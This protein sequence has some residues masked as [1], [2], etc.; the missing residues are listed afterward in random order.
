MGEARRASSWCRPW[1]RSTTLEIP[2]PDRVAF[3]TQTTLSVDE[4]GEIIGAL[5]ASPGS[6][7][8]RTKT[9]VTRPNRQIAV[10]QL[11]QESTWCS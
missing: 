11:A 6:S 4:T 7:A 3:I 10:K 9:S 2:D 1:R 8:P 5:R